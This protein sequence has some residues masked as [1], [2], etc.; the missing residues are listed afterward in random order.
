M[1]LHFVL[2]FMLSYQ[3]ICCIALFIDCFV[4]MWIYIFNKMV[5]MTYIL[6]ICNHIPIAYKYIAVEIYLI[7]DPRHDVIKWKHFPRYWP[8]VWN[9]P[10]IIEFP[11]QRPGT[12]R[13][14]VFFDLRLNERLSRQSRRRWFETPSRSLWR[15]WN[16]NIEHLPA[17]SYI[18]RVPWD[19]TISNDVH[20]LT[21]SRRFRFL[22]WFQFL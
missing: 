8:F 18:L 5:K 2:C 9:S 20:L 7:I 4:H 10:V 12:R 17:G 15:H 19:M 21:G 11:S 13:F 22:A 16:D 1:R 6:S 3:E 14:D